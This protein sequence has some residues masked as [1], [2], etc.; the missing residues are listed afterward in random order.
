MA[1][2]TWCSLDELRVR[3]GMEL[4]PVDVRMW[5]FR[6]IRIRLPRMLCHCRYKWSRFCEPFKTPDDSQ[7]RPIH[8]SFYSSVICSA[9][10]FY[11]QTAANVIQTC[12]GQKRALIGERPFAGRSPCQNS[13]SPIGCQMINYLP[14]Q[15]HHAGTVARKRRSLCYNRLLCC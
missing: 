10:G 2:F 9:R 4:S 3:L 1:T 5:S 11:T 6:W 14:L 8:S 12:C 15:A 13:P 7:L